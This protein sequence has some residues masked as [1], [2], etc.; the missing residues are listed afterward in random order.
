MT[1]GC[2][3]IPVKELTLEESVLGEY[4]F[5]NGFEETL[6]Y[7]FLDNGVHKYYASGKKVSENKWSI[8]NGDI[9]LKYDHPALLSTY[10]FRINADKS[11]THI[12]YME[13]GKRTERSKEGATYKK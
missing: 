9:H 1:V 12:A 5:K 7:V 3:T 10:V 11:I 13:D 2:E 4:E 6:K 8:V